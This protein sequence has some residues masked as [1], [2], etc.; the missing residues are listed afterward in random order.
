MKNQSYFDKKLNLTILQRFAE[1]WASQL[2]AIEEISLYFCS[3]KEPAKF[4][5]VF[6]IDDQSDSNDLETF[7]EW[8]AGGE[9]CTHIRRELA[10][11]YYPP[12][13]KGEWPMEWICFVEP[14][15]TTDHPCDLIVVESKVTLFDRR[16]AVEWLHDEEGS[17]DPPREFSVEPVTYYPDK[18]K[19]FRFNVSLKG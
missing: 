1:G 15:G 9:A 8:Q 4:A 3:S 7:I 6:S 5:L 16:A 12:L 10:D 18:R 17:D 11:A 2:A 13:E 14:A 19:G